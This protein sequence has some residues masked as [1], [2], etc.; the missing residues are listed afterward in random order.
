MYKNEWKFTIKIGKDLKG[1]LCYIL[2]SY[3][4]I[5]RSTNEIPR[6]S[7]VTV[8]SVQEKIRTGDLPEI[9]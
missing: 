2:N 1:N 7:C 4:E 8:T 5:S 6:Q 3:A 9:S